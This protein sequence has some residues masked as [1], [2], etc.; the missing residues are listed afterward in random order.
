MESKKVQKSWLRTGVA[1]VAL[2]VLSMAV[3]AD[4]SYAG[5]SWRGGAGTTFEQWSFP[6]SS[7]SPSPDAG[8]V[9]PY[10]TPSLW[11]GDRAMYFSSFDSRTGVWA[12]KTDEIDLQ[13]PN[14]P[15]TGDDTQKTIW[16]EITWKVAGLDTR[17]THDDSLMVGVDPEGGYTGMNFTRSDTSLG[18]GWF[19]TI[20]KVDIWPNP[21][22]EW[23]TVKGDIYIDEITIDTKCIPEPATFGLLIGGA[24]MAVR[25][26]QK[27]S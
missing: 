10:G 23:I 25:K 21:L 12:P 19:S 7:T 15:N 26:K 3:V 20:V 1:F 13:I 5:P 6:D 18:N 22:S 9:N 8:Y 11:V 27:K 4:A 16:A 14:N 2:I 17:T 24:F